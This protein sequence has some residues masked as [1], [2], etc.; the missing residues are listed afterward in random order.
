[1]RK[2]RKHQVRARHSKLHLAFERLPEGLVIYLFGVPRRAADPSSTGGTVRGAAKV[3]QVRP[4]ATHIRVSR[5]C[6]RS[7]KP[8]VGTQRRTSPCLQDSWAEEVCLCSKGRKG[9]QTSP[10]VS[11]NS[12]ERILR[13]KFTRCRSPLAAGA[14]RRQGLGQA[15]C[16][17]ALRS[18]TVY[19]GHGNPL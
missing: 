7:R 15:S 4:S 1:M 5:G 6:V 14:V 11:R 3:E 12:R 10:S 2:R 13:G 9:R 17:Q 16:G 8:E 18:S 19:R